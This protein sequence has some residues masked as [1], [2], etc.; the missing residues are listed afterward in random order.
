MKEED[1]G[2][3]EYRGV[4]VQHTTLPLGTVTGMNKRRI[5]L[6]KVR[7]C[8]NKDWPENCKIAQVSGPALSFASPTNSYRVPPAKVGACADVAID[9][10]TPD[11]EGDIITQWMIQDPQGKQMMTQPLEF[12]I[13]VTTA[14][15]S[16][17]DSIMKSAFGQSGIVP[18]QQQQLPSS[19]PAAAASASPVVSLPTPPVA[20]PFVPP[21]PFPPFPSTGSQP[22]GIELPLSQPAVDQP[23][24]QVHV[25]QP[26]GFPPPPIT[27]QPLQLPSQ[28]QPHKEMPG[29]TPP[30]PMDV[31]PAV[32]PVAAHEPAAPAAPSA[33]AEQRKKVSPMEQMH[34]M[35]FDDQEKNK[36]ALDKFKGDVA[37]AIDYLLTHS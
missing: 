10:Q 2:K 16:L 17:A 19:T 6:W 32:A 4:L 34:E 1:E 3:S 20:A 12:S 24:F 15:D 22:S 21:M 8:G 29:A 13:H 18:Q 25:P 26:F 36:K 30:A 35:G 7:N 33:P 14:V 37:Q 9:I 28:P 5:K 23:F 31:E 27:Q 11:V